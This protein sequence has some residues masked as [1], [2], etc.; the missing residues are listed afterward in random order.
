[1]TSASANDLI[2]LPIAVV[3]Q[4]RQDHPIWMTPPAPLQYSKKLIG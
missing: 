1:M 4:H 2:R 3:D